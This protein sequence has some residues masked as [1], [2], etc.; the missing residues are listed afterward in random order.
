[1]FVSHLYECMRGMKK[2]DKKRMIKKKKNKRNVIDGM[3][4]KVYIIN[5]VKT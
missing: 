1:M 3:L 5:N 4:D 2:R